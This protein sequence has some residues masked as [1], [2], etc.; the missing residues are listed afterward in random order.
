MTPFRFSLFLCAF[1]SFAVLFLPSETFAEEAAAPRLIVRPPGTAGTESGVESESDS[2][3]KLRA[4]EDKRREVSMKMHET[5]VKLIKESPELAEIHK[6]IMTLHRN[7]ANKLDKA[8]EMKKLLEE[9][10]KLDSDIA[11]IVESMA[12]PKAAK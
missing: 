6:K 3:K 8:P 1:T 10:D 4:L 12:P 7:L 2:E 5:R 9:A 11:A